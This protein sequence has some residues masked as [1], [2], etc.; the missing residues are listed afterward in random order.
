MRRTLAGAW[1]EW[2]ASH[3]RVRECVSDSEHKCVMIL[4]Q[5]VCVMLA[6]FVDVSA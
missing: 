3:E 2:L 4:Q 1:K 6:R 5:D